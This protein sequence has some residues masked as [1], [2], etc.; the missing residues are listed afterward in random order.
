MMK[1]DIVL[2][3]L[4]C[5]SLTA[6]CIV[7]MH[8][9]FH[10][11]RQLA[12]WLQYLKEVKTAPERK[13]F[14]KDRGL[15]AEIHYELNDILEEN[16]KQFRKL[17]HAEEAGRQILTNLSHDVRT[18]LASLSGY[19]EALEQENVKEEEAKEYLHTAY[20]KTLE[21]RELIDALF[22]LFKINSG[23]QKY[24]MAISDVNEL[25]RELIIDYMPI[26]AKE[27]IVFE[28]HIPGEEYFIRLDRLSYARI[29]NNLFQNALRHGNCTK[30]TVTVW[31]EDVQEVQKR[32][33]KKEETQEEDKEKEEAEKAVWIE[34]SNDGK[35]IPSNQLPYL[36]DRLYKGDASRRG[37]GNGLGLAIVKELTKVMQGNVT[38][39][40]TQEK[41]TAFCLSFP[42]IM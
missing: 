27:H 19:L 30:I 9:L 13:L 18:P 28:T 35:I 20:R 2:L 6:V 32:E 25:T 37:Q 40:S 33:G 17:L 7:L 14:V 3:L 26:A 24:E 22:D 38:V 4:L 1:A 11:R 39:T 41:G 10:M 23:E 34:I 21:L 29:V 31:K 12:E 8:T 36:F 16:R 5:M 42:N 15:L